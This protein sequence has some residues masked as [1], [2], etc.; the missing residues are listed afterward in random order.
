MTDMFDSCAR[1]YS[2][3]VQSSIAFSGLRHDFFLEAK[4]DILARVLRDH[5]G[6]AKPA[7]ALDI[8]CGVGLLHPR[9]TPLVEKL[10]AVD[11]SAASIERARQA[12]PGVEYSVIDGSLPY[13]D[14]TFDAVLAVCVVHHLPPGNWHT[15]AGEMHRVT[16]KGGLICVIEH[17]P[18]N[19]LTRLAVSRCS[20]D[21]DAV[22]LSAR[23]TRVLLEEAGG[24][25]TRTQFFLTVPSRRPFAARI[26]KLL[27]RLPVGAQYLVSAKA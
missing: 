22:L 12:N 16:R 27:G 7:T 8:G 13:R 20:L 24:S 19:P 4:A 18:L 14:D 5:F 3:E 15:F 6:A 2:D 21:A 10:V 26:E 23:R 9:L 1:S 11:T 17:N 25:E